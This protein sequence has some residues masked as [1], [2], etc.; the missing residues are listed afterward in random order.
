MI[1]GFL[2]IHHGNQELG[3]LYLD[4]YDDIVPRT[5]QNF[6]AFLEGTTTKPTWTYRNSVSHRLIPGF[7]IQFGDITKGDGTGSISIYGDAFDDENF[8]L[9]HDR[10]G[11]MSMANAGKNTNG[12]QFFVTFKTT[13]S[14]NG[15]HVVF[16]Y[17]DLTKSHSVLKQLEQI[18]TDPT[19]DRP[20][21]PVV[22]VDC[23]VLDDDKSNPV[24]TDTS[25]NVV[26]E[27]QKLQPPQKDQEPIQEE[28][29]Q[30]EEE[31]T[32]NMTKAQAIKNRLRKLKMKMN[33]ARQL[34]HKALLTEGEAMMM[35]GGNK[36]SRK[37]RQQQQNTKKTTDPLAY[38][39]VESAAS[40]L[41]RIYLDDFFVAL[42]ES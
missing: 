40:S 27:T 7:M 24:A 41:V 34:N 32:S 15:K 30:D 4:L 2:T 29:D 38:S 35:Q 20:L 42:L 33:Q 36:L 37:M 10:I 16:G 3:T 6:Q 14:L 12:S 28:D 8:K 11:T 22:I 18:T 39:L 17:V 13:P 9:Q 25:S 1:K 23:G 31:D 19:N 26:Q 21:Q 5:V